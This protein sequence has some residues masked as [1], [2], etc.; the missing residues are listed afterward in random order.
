MTKSVTVG[1]IFLSFLLIWIVSG[2]QEEPSTL[3]VG[4]DGAVSTYS[5]GQQEEFKPQKSKQFPDR[6]ITGVEQAAEVYRAGN[7]T[8]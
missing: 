4:P 5:G 1:V 8:P 2:C 7:L 3:P 6:I